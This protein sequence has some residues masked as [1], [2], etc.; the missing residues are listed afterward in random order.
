MDSIPAPLRRLVIRRANNRCE[1]CLLAQVGQEAT[2]HIDH[3]IPEAHGGKT[4][5]ENLALA[6]VSCSLR[7]GA[8]QT[9]VDAKTGKR[10]AL[11]HPRND[12]WDDHFQ[13]DGSEVEGLTP[14]GRAT[15]ELLKLNRPSILA[16]RAE[17][18]LRG[19]HPP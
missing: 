6:C 8:R 19:R 13:W 17:E 15:I 18:A 2:F 4:V 10:A 3:I 14:K 9:T 1:Y 12:V 11:F 5:A 16:I 7:K